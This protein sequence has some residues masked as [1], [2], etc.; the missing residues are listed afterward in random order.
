M[1]KQTIPEYLE[2]ERQKDAENELR[3]EE[4]AARIQPL[5]HGHHRASKG[6][7][8]LTSKRASRQISKSTKRERGVPVKAAAKKN[9]KKQKKKTAEAKSKKPRV[10]AKK[11]KKI[12]KK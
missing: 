9:Q 10:V 2:E 7:S 12:R 8:K 3:V 1:S 4:E 11:S 6:G 5:Q